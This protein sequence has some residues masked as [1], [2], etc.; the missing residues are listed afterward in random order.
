[1]TKG[2]GLAHQWAES[3]IC[4]GPLCFSLSHKCL[5]GASLRRKGAVR[6]SGE[7]RCRSFLFRRL[8]S[9]T[10]HLVSRRFIR[11]HFLRILR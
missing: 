4:E 2:R 11:G 6:K 5:G 8:L 7:L 1:M 9:N 10:H 3:E